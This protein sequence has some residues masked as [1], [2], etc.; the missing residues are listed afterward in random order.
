MHHEFPCNA[1]VGTRTL[2][3]ASI[4]IHPSS[5][6][7]PVSLMS[8]GDRLPNSFLGYLLEGEEENSLASYVEETRVLELEFCKEDAVTSASNWPWFEHFNNIFS[9][10]T[11]ISGISNAIDEGV[12]VRNS[13]IEI[14]NVSD[15]EDVQTPQMP[16][17][18]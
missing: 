3:L 8:V 11:K 2:V 12:H 17:S 14:V 18:P 13:K 16:N 9:S 10:I 7:A 6:V 1:L 5:I 15:E 4:A